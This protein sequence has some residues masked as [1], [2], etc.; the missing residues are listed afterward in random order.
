MIERGGS[1]VDL[2]DGAPMSVR[3]SDNITSHTSPV[4]AVVRTSPETVLHDVKAS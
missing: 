1:T 3:H 2:F 4:V